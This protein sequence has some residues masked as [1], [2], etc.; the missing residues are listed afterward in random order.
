MNGIS[1]LLSTD[2]F[3]TVNKTIIRELGLHEAIMIGELCSEY[4]YWEKC[5]KLE[6]DMFY[7]TRDNIEYNTGLSEHFQRKALKTLQEKEIISIEKRGL[8]AVNYYK[9][10]FDKL[11]ILLSTSASSRE[12][13]K[14]ESVNLNNKQTKIKEEKTNSKE[15]VQNPPTFELG[16]KPKVRESLYTKCVHMIDE[17][18]SQH[19]CGNP[20]RQKLISYLNYRLQIN[21]KP[22][23]V[24]MWKGMLNKLDK[25][26]QEGYGYEPIID[27][28]I[29][30][31]Y[32]S[33][34][35]PANCYTETTNKPWEAGVKSVA[36]TDEELAELRRIDAEREAKGLRTKF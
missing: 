23:Y 20:V 12:Q 10:N 13:L 11:L 24:N 35:P 6:N 17:F 32:L 36:Y 21:D 34:Y 8:P 3:I 15:L 19:N 2:G 22:L 25:L 4:N 31:G 5:N 9:I 28:C 14:I 30:R 7:S 27:Y 16:R 29:E 33:F 18:I 1:K 26:H